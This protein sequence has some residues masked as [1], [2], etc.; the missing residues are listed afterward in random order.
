MSCPLDLQLLVNGLQ[1]ATLVC[2]EMGMIVMTNEAAQR[3]LGAD[4][5]SQNVHAIIWDKGI[6]KHHGGYINRYIKS[7][8]ATIIGKTD[9]HYDAKH[10]KG[11]RVPIALRVEQLNQPGDK[12]LFMGTLSPRSLAL[13]DFQL[14]EKVG[15]GAFGTVWRAILKG[16]TSRS[17]ALKII[18]KEHVQSMRDVAR[19]VEERNILLQGTRHPFIITCHGTFH[20]AFHVYFVMD[21][22]GGGDLVTLLNNCRIDE[23]STRIYLGEL[24]LA[25][26]FLHDRD[27]IMRDLKLENILVA[28]NGH[29]RL[30]DFGI[31]V[32]AVQASTL[33]GTPDY[34]APE[35]IQGAGSYTCAVDVWALG[36]VMREMLLGELPWQHCELADKFASILRGD[37]AEAEFRGFTASSPCKAL[38][39]LLLHRDPL[40]RPPLDA[41]REHEFFSLMDWDDLRNERIPAP[42]RPP[43]KERKQSLLLAKLHDAL[44]SAD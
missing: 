8:C 5:T 38:L 30:S 10:H 26:Q 22:A 12:K 23:A 29:L 9:R 15:T 44:A 27:I 41:V 25:L 17:L 31:S 40:Q 24:I 1:H 34:M 3:M 20:D 18:K 16:D 19:I 11:H 14:C 2:D 37:G 36:C 33:C 6:A 28:E 4:Y 21:F 39:L 13:N 43:K 32:T 35:I 42:I 7:G